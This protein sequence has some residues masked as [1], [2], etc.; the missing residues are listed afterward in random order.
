M[1][2]KNY[3]GCFKEVSN[4]FQESFKGFSRK[5]EWCFKGVSRYF[6]GVSRKI[7]GFSKK[8][9]KFKRCFKKISNN[10]S[11]VFQLCLMTFRFAILFC[12]YLIAASQAEGGLV[13]LSVHW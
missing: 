12:M 1:V 2:L 4:V 7:K 3:K 13:R 6:K 9:L 8:P 5:I 10:V 11:R